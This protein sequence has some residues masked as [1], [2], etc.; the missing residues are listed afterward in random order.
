MTTKQF[1]KSFFEDEGKTRKTLA[2]KG[3]EYSANDNRFH[4]LEKMQLLF[5]LIENKDSEFFPTY[6]LFCKN[7]ISMT[8]MINGHLE[9]TEA[10]IDE[11]I[12]DPIN[13][14]YI[15]KSQMKESIG[16][17]YEE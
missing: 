7:F 3:T 10:N 8:D 14:L 17:N 5:S 6:A 13:Y 1:D 9:I 2:S 11:K 15:M 4:N 12:G 16:I